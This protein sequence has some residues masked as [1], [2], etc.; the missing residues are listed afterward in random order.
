MK[1]N[2]LR[3]AVMNEV[4]D[5]MPFPVLAADS[6]RWIELRA[7]GVFEVSTCFNRCRSISSDPFTDVRRAVPEYSSFGLPLSK[8]FHDLS[9]GEYD[10]FQVEGK[11]TLFPLDCVAKC[12]DILFCNPAAYAQN[13]DVLA[14]DNSVNSP[15]HF[16]IADEVFALL[17]TCAIRRC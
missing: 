5:I 10:V 1:V 12:V 14:I 11:R 4:L 8:E 2:Q 16:E 13:H 17:L 9:I 3:R 7:S 6:L 15:S